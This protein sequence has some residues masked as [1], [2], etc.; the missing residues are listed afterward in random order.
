M[1]V[2]GISRRYLSRPANRTGTFSA[3]AWDRLPSA[4]AILCVQSITVSVDSSS[5]DALYVAWQ[6]VLDNNGHVFVQENKE[7]NF[8]I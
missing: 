2:F 5:P 6:R 8:Q 4:V 3:L 7:N 1:Y